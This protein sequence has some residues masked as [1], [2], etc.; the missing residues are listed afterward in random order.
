MR[1]ALSRDPSFVLP[2]PYMGPGR[3]SQEI[4]RESHVPSQC[5]REQKVLV[6]GLTVKED[7]TASR[8]QNA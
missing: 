6:Q 4:W 5:W 7:R 3:G 8:F 1:P 2:S